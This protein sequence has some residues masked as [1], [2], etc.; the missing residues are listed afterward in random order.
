M[1]QGWGKGGG[2]STD[3]EARFPFAPGGEVGHVV[4]P[5]DVGGFV[6]EGFVHAVCREFLEP[7]FLVQDIWTECLPDVGPVREDVLVEV[8][9]GNLADPASDSGITSIKV[10]GTVHVPCAPYCRPGCERAR[11]EMDTQHSRVICSGKVA[12]IFILSN[13]LS[14]KLL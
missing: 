2:G 7:L 13:L 8:S 6:F 3:G 11:G 14:Q 1:I 9:P 5:L 4:G 12:H 10:L